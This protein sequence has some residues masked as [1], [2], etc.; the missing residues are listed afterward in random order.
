MT[1]WKAKYDA[2]IADLPTELELYIQNQY[3]L[4]DELENEILYIKC[5]IYKHKK[6]QYRKEKVEPNPCIQRYNI[7]YEKLLT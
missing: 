2:V 7:T 6:S 3:Q 1:D 5:S 4:I